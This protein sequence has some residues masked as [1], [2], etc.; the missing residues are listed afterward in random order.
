M[1]SIAK[2]VVDELEY[3]CNSGACIDEHT[4]DQLIVYAALASGTSRIL[5]TPRG[6]KSSLHLET[7]VEVAKQ[8]CG[9]RVTI[10]S[11][12]AEVHT[13]NALNNVGHV[14]ELRLITCEGIGLYKSPSP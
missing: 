9:A 10:E 6:E 11:M 4:A 13:D 8:L 14:K 5:C 2:D 7:V 12:P 3:L 1:E